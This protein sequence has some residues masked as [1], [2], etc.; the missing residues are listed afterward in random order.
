MLLSITGLTKLFGSL[1]AVNNVSFE[2]K[3]GQIVSLIGPNG[4]GKTT[5]FHLITGFLR[6]NSGRIS[7]LGKGLTR[8]KPFQIAQ[9]GISRS[10]QEGKTFSNL[11]VMENI[12][13]GVD[14]HGHTGVFGAVFNTPRMRREEKESK[15]KASQ[16]LELLE[17]S[18]WKDFPAKNLTYEHVSR[19]G[20]AVALGTEPKLL[21]L[22][23]PMMGMN[24]TET[25][26]MMSLLTRIRDSG[27]TI[28]LIEHDMRA[29]MGI[30]DWIVVLDYGEKIAEG[31]TAEIR[32][33]KAVIKAYLGV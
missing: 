6:P 15:E 30:S 4:A 24:P 25:K 3:D 8:L 1:A 21:L 14:C 11:S 31:T 13:I 28:L 12:L 10:F 7:F 18:P 16:I 26:A 20:I 5:V 27:T 33:N 2:V 23:E 32:S 17:L 22:D 19:L 29:V 9:K